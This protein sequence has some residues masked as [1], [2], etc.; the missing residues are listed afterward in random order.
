MN[1]KFETYWEYLIRQRNPWARLINI[2][3]TPI[4]LSMLI[5]KGV[6]TTQPYFWIGAILTAVMGLQ[7][8]RHYWFKWNDQHRKQREL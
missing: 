2:S 1:K 6:V 8:H 4:I 5:F 7:Q 3:I